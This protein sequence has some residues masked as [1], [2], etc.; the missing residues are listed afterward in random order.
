[1]IKNI[2]VSV[3]V[4][5]TA[6]SLFLNADESA[7]RSVEFQM[8]SGLS[9]AQSI[10]IGL[11]N[12]RQVLIA[13]EGMNYANERLNEASAKRYP[14]FSGAASYTRLDGVSSMVVGGGPTATSYKMGDVNNA[15]G[16]LS[17]KQ[18]IYSGG[19]ISAGV[20]AAL[21]NK[22]IQSNQNDDMAKR[23][24]FLVKKAYYDVLLNEAIVDVNRKS[25]A[26]TRAH[27][28]DIQKMAA[29]GLSSRY[30]LLRVQVQL[31]NIR[32][33]RI[34]SET[35]LQNVKLSF[36]N[37]IGLPLE[38]AESLKLTDKLSLPANGQEVPE[39]SAK[40]EDAFHNRSDLKISQLRVDM[41]KQSI[42]LAE[43][44][45]KPALNLMWNFGYEY[46]SR[47]EFLTQQWGDY[48]NIMAV[49]SIPLFEWGRIKARIRQEE[50]LL[51][52]AEMAEM[53]VRERIKLE[54]RQSVSSVRD[55][56]IL[57]ETQNE[58]IKQAEEG[59]RLAEIGYKNG[60]NT[61]LEVMD[62]Q[63]ALDTASKNYV[64]SLYQYNLAKANLDL[65]TGR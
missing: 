46:P 41:Q 37:T 26:L 62:T 28:N 59:L 65:V 55:S 3:L 17:I 50:S 27:L 1:M 49:A 34:Q 35:N 36:F 64:Q 25:E 12:N 58:N 29:Q 44:E 38:R 57:I 7:G 21:L 52:Q 54:V 18:P 15:K 4:A 5:F 6:I 43:A 10:E 61:Q 8:D 32:A 2:I 20:E 30:E 47:K 31:T 33:L 23:V 9:L 40:L 19:R 16:E 51:K 11:A 60:V 24:V 14:A 53:D 39:H 42:V 13:R 45:G 22:S 63:M 48:Q 56:V